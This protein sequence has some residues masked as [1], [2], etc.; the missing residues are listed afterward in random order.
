MFLMYGLALFNSRCLY[1]LTW[2]FYF[3]AFL[4][5]CKNIPAKPPFNSIVSDIQKIKNQKQR[6]CPKMGRQLKK[7]YVA[8]TYYGIL[9][10]QE[11]IEVATG[12]ERCLKY[13]F[14]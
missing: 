8:F 9:C 5:M 13:I 3:E 12:M 7:C 14:Q 6:M 10:S 11:N 2:H 1:S 4:R